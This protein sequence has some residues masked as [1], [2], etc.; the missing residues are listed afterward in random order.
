MRFFTALSA[1][2]LASVVSAAQFNITVGKDNTNVFDPPSIT[3]VQNGDTVTFQFVSKAHTVTQSTFDRPCE[4]KPDGVDSQAVPVPA[5]ATSF[6]QWT[7]QINNATGPQWFYCKTGAHCAQSGMVF[8]I[9]PTPERTFQSFQDRAKGLTPSTSSSAP[10]SP[11][12]T[13]TDNAAAHVTMQK[14]ATFLAA[15][16]VVAGLIL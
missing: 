9:N 5:N 8:A 7:I 3:G 10:G 12:Q 11:A 13:G 2:A 1:A 4:A 14:A 16:G 15:V 6:P